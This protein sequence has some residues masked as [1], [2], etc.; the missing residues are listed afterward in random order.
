MLNQNSLLQYLS[1]LEGVI[2]IVVVI[3]IIGAINTIFI[4][5]SVRRNNGA[6][7]KEKARHMIQQ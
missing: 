5:Y 4:A 7:K 2:K 1:A 6:A 3:I